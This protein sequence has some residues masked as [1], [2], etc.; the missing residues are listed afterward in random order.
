MAKRFPIVPPS[1]KQL[2]DLELFLRKCATVEIAAILSGIPRKTIY[3][4]IKLGRQGHSEYTAVTDLIDHQTAQLSEAILAPI[5]EEALE[6]KN[7]SAL[8]FL[9]KVRI[10]PHET[11][12]NKK[13]DKMEEEL[14]AADSLSDAPS[15]ENVEAAE[16]RVLAA[17]EEAENA[18]VSH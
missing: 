5:R 14:D 9:Y 15:E 8:Q 2:K 12:W 16:A 18:G 6:N 10:Q 13:I 3:E 1:I 11:R 4:W 17:L 7:L